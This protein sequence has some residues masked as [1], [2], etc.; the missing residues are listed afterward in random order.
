M[1]RREIYEIWKKCSIFKKFE[2]FSQNSYYQSSEF[3]S[4]LKICKNIPNRLKLKV[5]K[6]KL[7]LIYNF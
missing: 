4:T 3:C 7:T 2:R 6:T 5:K 1:V